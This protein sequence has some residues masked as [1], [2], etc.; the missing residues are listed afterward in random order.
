MTSLNFKHAVISA[1]TVYAIGILTFVSS[2]FI[3]L[4]DDPDYQA[5]LVLMIAIIPAAYLGAHLYYR[6]AHNTNGFILGA[7][8]FVGAMVLDAL[9]TVPLVIIPNGGNYISFFGDRGFWLIGVEYV[10]VVATYWQFGVINRQ[11]NQ[12]I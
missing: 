4:L 11:E 8:M 2:Y 10:A 12:V 6:K 9:I 5:N 7:S 1:A 3:P